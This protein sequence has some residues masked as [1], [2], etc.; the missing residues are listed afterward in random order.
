MR[1]YCLK[2][3]LPARWTKVLSTRE[4]R[5]LLKH[6]EKTF[7]VFKLIGL[8]D[9]EDGRSS[10]LLKNMWNIY[11]SDDSTMTLVRFFSTTLG[12]QPASICTVDLMLYICITV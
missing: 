6:G 3:I 9:T 1:M 7:I 12:G 2:W 5:S 4:Y 11:V 10:S 8:M